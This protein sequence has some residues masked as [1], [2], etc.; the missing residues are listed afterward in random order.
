MGGEADGPDVAAAPVEKVV[1]YLRRVVPVILEDGPNHAATLDRELGTPAAAELV[2]KFICEAGCGALLVERVSQREEE[3][4]DLHQ[5][6][7]EK[8]VVT[9]NLTN[10]VTYTGKMASVVCLKKGE[11][12]FILDKYTI[13][14]SCLS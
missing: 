6:G 12:M 1:A 4:G 2:R 13:D 14:K 7:E 11:V 10:T 9:Y 5:P 3:E 8:E